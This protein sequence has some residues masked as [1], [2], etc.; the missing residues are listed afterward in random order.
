MCSIEYISGILTGV[1]TFC[2]GIRIGVEELTL[3]NKKIESDIQ[4]HFK[5][6]CSQPLEIT[7]RKSAVLLSTLIYSHLKG[8]ALGETVE[9]S[10]RLRSDVNDLAWE[11]KNSIT[12]I[13]SKEFTM[14][15][16]KVNSSDY[17]MDS[18]A[19]IFYGGGRSIC[20][21]FSIIE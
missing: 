13:V 1:S 20:I 21:H 11:L 17:G 5:G 10:E 16:V 15:S 2:R 8:G 3:S 9:P 7:D 18:E 19:L 4:S 12:D 14:Y 6:E